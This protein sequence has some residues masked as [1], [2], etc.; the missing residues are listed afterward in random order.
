MCVFI[1]VC[2]TI[3]LDPQVSARVGAGVRAVR[4]TVKIACVRFRAL[5]HSKIA[6]N[7]AAGW[8]SAGCWAGLGFL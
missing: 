4:A 6:I 3:S 8:L 2:K 1:S 7:E 5:P